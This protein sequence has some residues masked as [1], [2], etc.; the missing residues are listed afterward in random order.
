M[1]LFAEDKDRLEKWKLQQNAASEYWGVFTLR[2][3]QAFTLANEEAKQ[4]NQS[5]IGT[6]HLLLGLIGLGSGVAVNILKNLGLKLETIR[7][8]VNKQTG[9]VSAKNMLNYLPMTPQ[10]MRVLDTAKKEAQALGHTYVGT[11]HLLLG[12]LAEND[13]AAWRIFK[14]A[15]TDFEKTRRDIFEEITPI[16]PPGGSEPKK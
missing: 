16:Y 5:F 6:E 12:L 2:S 15:N 10:V 4:V 1:G 9:F 7:A 8:E 14:M 3:K 11:E 13:G